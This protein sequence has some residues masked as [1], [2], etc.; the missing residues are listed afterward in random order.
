MK[1]RIIAG[2]AGAA[3]AITGGLLATHEGDHRYKAFKPV[4]SDP[5]TICRGRTKGV[6]EG[7][8]AT[9]EQC[10]EWE[11]E[12]IEEAGRVVDYCI[13]VPMTI[14]QRA[15]LTSFA[16]NV[17][18]GRKGTAPNYSDGRDGLCVNR[19]GV[20]SYI[21]RMANAGKWQEACDGLLQFRSAGGIVY[22][23]LVRRRND[24]RRACL[25]PDPR[26]DFSNVVSGSYVIH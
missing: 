7:D 8:T 24:E 4:P 2:I 12:D 3:L 11:R 18:Y 5:W 15:A 10:D 21:S 1:G 9:K 17:G 20:P 13:K 19:R 26:P 6:K 25:T 23:G 22:R 16:Y 14:G